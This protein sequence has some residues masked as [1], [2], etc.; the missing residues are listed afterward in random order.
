FKYDNKH[1]ETKD[2]HGVVVN[3]L[4]PGKDNSA[5]VPHHRHLRSRVLQI[6]QQRCGCINTGGYR[7]QHGHDVSYKR[8]MQTAV[9]PGKEYALLKEEEKRVVETDLEPGVISRLALTER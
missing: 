6:S 7:D 3:A 5:F 8:E 4:L 2:P 9:D 1:N